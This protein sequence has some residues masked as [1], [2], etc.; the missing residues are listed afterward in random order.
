MQEIEYRSK[1]GIDELAKK[2]MV[3]A[4]ATGVEIELLGSFTVPFFL[5]FFS[6][7]F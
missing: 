6:P 1:A 4:V 3:V 7:F 5:P 2:A